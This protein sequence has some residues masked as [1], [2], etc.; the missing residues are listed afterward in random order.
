METSI[1]YEV[2]SPWA[3][4]DAVPT[5]AISPRL[6]EIPGKN[7][8]FFLN[9]KIAAE[10]MS[11]VIEEKLKEKYSS[12]NI[13]RFTRIPNISMVETQDKDNYVEW[14]KGLDAIIFIHGD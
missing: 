7:I 6:N 9:S 13:S 1:Q 14:L 5:K 3:E 10:P 4:V 2:M 11:I 12:L 8:G